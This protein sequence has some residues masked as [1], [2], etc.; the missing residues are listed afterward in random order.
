MKRRFAT[1]TR[2]IFQLFLSFVFFFSKLACLEFLICWL[3]FSSFFF[4]FLLLL[5]F[6]YKC[7]RDTKTLSRL[8]T[9]TCEYK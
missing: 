8:K 9:K 7:M 4:L 6:I 5:L 2:S 3:F 1:S